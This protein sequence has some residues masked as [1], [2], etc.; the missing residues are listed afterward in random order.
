M[1]ILKPFKSRNETFGKTIYDPN[2][3]KHFFIPN[4]TFLDFK[5]ENVVEEFDN[6][7]FFDNPSILYSPIRIYFDLTLKCNLRC[8][9]CL[10]KSGKPLEDE[11]S[12]EDSI[13]VID[14]L[15]NDSIFDIRFSGGEPTLKQG[16]DK[17]LKR[18]KESGLTVTLN[19]NGIYNEKII[20]KLIEIKPDEI[21]VSLDGYK[22]HNDYIRGEGNFEKAINSIKLLKSAGCRVTIN[23]AITSVFDDKDIRGLLGF[24]DKFCDD[25]SFFHARPIGRAADM[26]DKIVNYDQLDVIMKKIE[27]MKKEYPTLAV[28]TRSYSLKSNS[29]GLEDT[30]SFSLLEGGP[31]GFTRFNVMSNGDL[32]A[33]GCV[34]Y[35]EPK[36]QNELKLGNIISENYSL[37]NIWRHSDKL[38]QIRATSSQ[39]KHK[40]DN[41]AEYRTKCQGFT[42]E[43]ELYGQVNPEGNIYCKIKSKGDD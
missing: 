23:S 42:L 24:A 38:R 33:G 22:E 41:C 7:P 20:D 37:L 14:G 11:L 40:C 36:L 28:R 13:K 12:L 16:W 9:I 27:T 4:E 19:T 17:I 32:Y 26:K 29:I 18:A 3:F 2:T 10:N 25:I 1:K 35:V 30:E 31:D 21:T 39:L 15:K 43:M 8:K 34:P 6:P 5:K